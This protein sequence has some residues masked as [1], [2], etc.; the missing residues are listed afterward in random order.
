MSIPT[1]LLKKNEDR[2]LRSGHLWV[3]SNEIDVSKTP[4]ST[5]APGE[6]VQIVASSGR[7]LGVGY[8]NPQVLLCA[9]LL[10]RDGEQVDPEF[11]ARR[12]AA[13]LAWRER[14]YDSPFYRMIYG[15]SDGLPGL[16]V[17]RY[18][19]VLVVQIT[20]AG[21]AKWQSVIIDAL[22]KVVNPTGILLHQD[23]PYRELEGLPI[24]EPDRIGEVP[25]T[26]QLTEHG[27]TFEIPLQ[28]G[29]KTGW[30]YD[31]EPNRARLRHF[32]K[33]QRVLDVFSYLGAWGL[34]A[35]H[36][37]ASEV[38]CI[39]SSSK[40]IEALQN[41]ARLNQ[42]ENK[43]QTE[44][45]DAFAAL[46]E[47]AAS[48]KTFDVIILDPPALIKRRKDIKS[49]LAGYHHLNQ[50]G[51][52]L[53]APNGILISASCS[54]HLPLNDLTDALRRASIH[55]KRELQVIGF[56]H[57]GADHPIHPAISETEY[58]KVIYSR[59]VN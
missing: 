39:D 12:I 7:K 46:A 16:V 2:R 28:D 1:L 26:L 49:G 13:A 35:A 54:L 41:N 59:V 40:A 20:T 19:D 8:A 44:C 17:D 32:V 50:L 51:M 34:Q 38:H 18:G 14:Y 45:G 37:G 55:L 6:L 30:F 52:A 3:Y 33:G 29:Q 53:L 42:M 36:F 23:N 11:F 48:G 10:V 58:L 9:R 57:Q 56:G 4:L 5:I 31:Q 47:L 43:V 21:M 15:E 22:Q 27:V 25:S 24:G